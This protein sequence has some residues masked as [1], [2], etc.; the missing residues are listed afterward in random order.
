MVAALMPRPDSPLI[1]PDRATS[2]RRVIAG[3]R[4][5]RATVTTPNS[6]DDLAGGRVETTP[7]IRQAV[8]CLLRPTGRADETAW[9]ERVTPTAVHVIVLDPDIA[10]AATSTITI[11][12]RT[13]D[14]IGVLT[15]SNM[16][17]QRVICAERL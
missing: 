4:P 6:V 15:D 16:I 12:A 7:T 9:A 11:G 10:V 8:P 2:V 5:D 17:E 14:T 13:F 1:H 3:Y